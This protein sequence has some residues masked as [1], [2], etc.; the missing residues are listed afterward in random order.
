MKFKGL[1]PTERSTSKISFSAC[2]ARN[3]VQVRVTVLMLV[4]NFLQCIARL[5]WSL[6]TL[7]KRYRCCDQL[8]TLPL[9]YL[10]FGSRTGSRT[11]FGRGGGGVVFFLG[12]D[13]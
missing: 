2:K 6:N 10:N 3:S 11:F 1:Y 7:S 9:V 4:C 13:I 12:G 5:E 8:S